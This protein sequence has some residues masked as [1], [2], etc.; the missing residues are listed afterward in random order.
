MTSNQKPDHSG[1]RNLSRNSEDVA[2]YYDEWAEDYDQTLARWRYQAPKRVAAR[3]HAVLD[4]GSII[5]DAGCGT[6]LSGE[7]LSETGFSRIDGIDVSQRSLDVAANRG[8]YRSLQQVDMQKLPLPI[9]DNSYDGLACVGVMT[10]L[11]DSSGT[12]R[13]F[14]RILRPGGVMV[15]TQRTDIF[16]ERDFPAVLKELEL[17][18]LIEDVDISDP[19]PYLPE[20]EEFGDEVMVRYITGRAAS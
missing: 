5:L 20:N 2:Q 15:L 14:C 9:D 17:Q 11:P 10:Y 18:G 12:L 7:A 4:P 3:L 19:G 1:L 13:E 6:G 8:V 16:E